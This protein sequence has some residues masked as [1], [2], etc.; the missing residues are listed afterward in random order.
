MLIR[1]LGSTDADVPE[2]SD[3]L[4]MFSLPATSEA[5]AVEERAEKAQQMYDSLI[6]V[7]KRT[8]A[9]ITIE[10]KERNG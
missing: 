6:A 5:L 9:K 2:A 3:L 10:R 4:K 7:G 1:I 8:G